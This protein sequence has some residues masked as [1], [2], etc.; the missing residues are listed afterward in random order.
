MSLGRHPVLRNTLWLYVVTIGGYALPLLTLPYLAR[1]LSL[2]VFGLVAYAQSL[3]WNC[4]TLTDYGFNLTATRE[5]AMYR[6]NT[7][8]LSRLLSAVIT[9]KALLTGLGFLLYA[10]VVLW[11]DN[12]RAH[13]P[14]FLVS[15]LSVLG[16]WLFPLWL[17]QGLE[18]MKQ[19]AVRDF[20]A[21]LLGLIA[22][23]RWC[24]EIKTPY[25]RRP[26]PR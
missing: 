5:V 23:L 21:K 17:Y 19:I 14:L 7:E 18:N 11:M 1:V 6:D 10:G 2:E 24:M 4:I 8:R 9:A 3:V 22:L 12:T 25:G 20:L 15:F 13:W 26:R 16:Y